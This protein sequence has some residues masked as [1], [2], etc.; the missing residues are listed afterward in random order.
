M[1][2]GCEYNIDVNKPH[3]FTPCDKPA[4]AWVNDG[5]KFYLCAEHYDIVVVKHPEVLETQ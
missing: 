4:I 5:S 1:N 2:H 3:D